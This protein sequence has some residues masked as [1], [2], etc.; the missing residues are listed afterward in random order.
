MPVIALTGGIASGKSTVA[1]HL[2]RL[3]A[4]VIDADRVAREVVE[5]GTPAL[6]L[7]RAA[8]GDD[9]VDEAGRLDRAALGRLVFADDEARRT[10]NSIVHPAV[11]ARVEEK[12]RKALAADPSAV[13]VYDVPLLAE[14]GPAAAAGYDAVV[15]VD[16][17][18]PR[19]I[20]R[21][22]RL[23]GMSRDDA[24]RRVHAQADDQA[25]LA[26]A[27][28]VI[29]ANGTLEETLT[30]ADE[31]WRRLRALPAGRSGSRPASGSQNDERR[32]DA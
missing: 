15:V 6:R 9:I 19:R 29:D 7:L 26:L 5:P 10:L 13:V 25:R 31:A 30:R 3:G 23:R 24:L 21:L 14:G 8:F 27:D 22:V 2:A 18:R 32:R 17:A 4:V 11:R 16:A 28:I 12:I 20:D 1:G